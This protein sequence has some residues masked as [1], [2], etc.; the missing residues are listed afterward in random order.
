VSKEELLTGDSIE[1]G[2]VL[3]GIASSG[4]HS[5]GLSLARKVLPQD[6]ATLRLLLEPTLIY[7]KLT[8]KL[9]SSMREAIKGIAHITGGGWRN[10]FRLNKGVGYHIEN[11]LP[12]PEVFTMLREH[13]EEQEMYSTF[14]MGMGLAIIAEAGKA[15]AV[16][17]IA[18][19]LGFRAQIVGRVTPHA[20]VLT[21]EGKSVKLKG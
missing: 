12:E 2:Q 19:A 13:V 11:P 15:E 10:V 21:I 8:N 7:A 9:L 20:E 3:V 6:D 17:G 5:N 16:A 18:Q 4:I 1:S 14:N